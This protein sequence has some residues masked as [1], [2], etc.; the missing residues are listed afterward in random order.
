[1]HL[2]KHH[3]LL[4][5]SL[6]GIALLLFISA[7]KSEEN[8][9]ISNL[10]KPDITE[11]STSTKRCSFDSMTEA[12]VTDGQRKVA[13]VVGVGNFLSGVTPLR[14]T[15]KDAQEFADL[16]VEDYGY[17]RQNLCILLNADATISNVRKYFRKMTDL[18]KKMP[19]GTPDEKKDVAVFYMS[20]HGSLV[21]NN[22][23]D[24]KGADFEKASADHPNGMDSTMLLYDSW[25][26]GNWDL[27][28]DEMYGMLGGLLKK[29][30]NVSVILD[31]CHSGSATKG[32]GGNTK[33]VKEADRPEGF[34]QSPPSN[35][36][37]S[38]E[39]LRNK[40]V[41]LGAAQDEELALELNELEHGVFTEALLRIGKVVDNT[42]LTYGKL[43][44]R[45]EADMRLKSRSQTPVL[46]G[47]DG[48]VAF[49]TANRKLP[50]NRLKV[51]QVDP[52]ILLKGNPLPG[53]GK[54]AIFNVFNNNITANESL[55]TD[56]VKAQLMILESS[57][58]G[59]AVAEIIKGT[60]KEKLGIGD[61]AVMFKASDSYEALRVRLKSEAEPNGLSQNLVNK[62]QTK[63]AGMSS[64]AGLRLLDT[65]DTNPE[66]IVEYNP[67]DSGSGGK[68][69]ILIHSSDSQ[70]TFL[71][72]GTNNDD[73]TAGK[74]F[75]KL[76]Q[77]NVQKLYINLHGQNG[78]IFED[79]KTLQVKIVKSENPLPNA[80]KKLIEETG[81]KCQ[82]PETLKPITQNQGKSYR[83]PV[84]TYFRV[85]VTYKAPT[86]IGAKPLYIGLVML[87]ASG[88][89]NGF[90]KKS[91]LE[92][93]LNPGET[94]SFPISSTGFAVAPILGRE[95][96]VV[97]GTQDK[98]SWSDVGSKGKDTD[99]GI[100]NDADLTPWT[101]TKI[102]VYSFDPKA[103]SS[104][105]AAANH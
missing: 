95:V 22:P 37:T 2:W 15:V 71:V 100:E 74:I 48:M 91:G 19:D 70:R 27:V 69:N 105:I 28:D 59:Q 41:Y 76:E 8:H 50:P 101:L 68:R 7:C 90:P 61:F 65:T 72:T 73:D 58:D 57:D 39:D 25:V 14:Y 102:P 43:K 36:E 29:T 23:D 9:T 51:A 88:S 21:E 53:L 45:I 26:N 16:L 79:D 66:Y 12:I 87:G 47:P 46:E 18:I 44:A 89:T 38:E 67:K 103:E 32:I 83:I 82:N 84:C 34:R 31:T 78:E 35:H 3:F 86:T 54:G 13:L 93:R 6:V 10:S 33:A 77:L 42:P 62:I 80:N 63:I 104:G 92:A 40:L 56:R 20:S 17:P 24:Q 4:R 97:I 49:G 11:S 64:G 85:E 30:P 98:R 52:T 55:D 60:E 75:G 99:L 81:V 5:L 1:M 94:L 96:Y